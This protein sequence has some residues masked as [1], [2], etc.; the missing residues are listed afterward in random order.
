[1]YFLSGYLALSGI[2]YPNTL[3][4]IQD[5]YFQAYISFLIAMEYYTTGRKQAAI[6][7]M[8]SCHY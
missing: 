5:I 1:M 7:R 3:N 8:L 4:A 2:V 6:R